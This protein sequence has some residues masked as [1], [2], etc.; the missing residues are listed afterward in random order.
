M[1]EQVPPHDV[2][3]DLEDRAHEEMRS[4]PE[5]EQTRTGVAAV[6]DVLAEVDR[7]DGAPLDEHLGT[8]ERAHE[9]LRSALDAD[10]GEPGEPA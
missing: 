3:P 5:P 10:P 8:Y 2:D 4:E 9:A 7:L 6:D 1:T